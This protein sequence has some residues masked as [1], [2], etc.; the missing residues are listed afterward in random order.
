MNFEQGP[1]RPP[2]EAGSLLIRLT[3]NCPWNQC[4]FCMTYKG[5]KFSLRPVPEIKN[6]IDTAKKIAGELEVLSR[7]LG[8]GGRID[9]HVAGEAYRRRGFLSYHLAVWLSDGGKN[10]FLQ[11][12]DSLIMKT[13]DLV[14]VLTHLRA[15]FPSV[16]RITTYA[17]SRTVV[18]KSAAELAELARLGLKRVH[19]GMESGSDAVLGFIKKGARAEDHIAAARK[20]KEAGISVCQYVILGMGG[21]RWAREHPLETARVINASDPDFV[22]FRSLAVKE[23]T[24]L[25]RLAGEGSFVPLPEDDVVRE[26]RLLIEHLEGIS[27]RLVSDH[28]LNL[29]EEV[30]G[31]LPEDKERLLGIIDRYLALPERERLLFRLGRRGGVYRRLDD[32]GEPATRL[33]LEGAL[34]T[35]KAEGRVEEAIEELRQ[36]FV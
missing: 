17:R 19:V 32:L 2:S 15:V 10:V 25:A 1:I 6:D 33:R 9:G 24:P 12:A 28:I 3:R 20:L 29:L 23:G 4:A 21:V 30:E 22:R 36:Q 11:D 27:T 34:A 8:H 14:E 26:E 16:E 31:R 18:K 7:Q 13:P 35:L 5:K